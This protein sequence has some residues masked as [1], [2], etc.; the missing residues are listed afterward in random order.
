MA[1]PDRLQ[2]LRT[3]EEQRGSR[4]V[5]L[6]TGTRGPNY[7]TIIAADAPPL[8][9]WHLER[10]GQVPQI[11]LLLYS[12]GGHTL[13]GFR[14]PG[15]IREYCKRFCVLIPYRAHSS[16]TLVA[17]G[18]DEIVMTPLAELSPVDPSTNGPFNPPVPVPV[19]P[20]ELP[21]TLPVS[22][23]DVVGYMNLASEEAKISGSEAMRG[24]F[25]RLATD[26]RPLALGQVFRARSQ[27]R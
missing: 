16:A 3:L 24:V 20:G 10:I 17:L 2:L 25:E 23:E 4:V 1:R 5:A 22:V 15:L 27:I 13:S 11:D 21:P 18:A 9:Y 14:I 6:L 26:V 12:Q 7:A 8:L 19:A